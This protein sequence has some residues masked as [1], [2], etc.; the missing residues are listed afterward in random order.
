M[1]DKSKKPIIIWLLSGCILIYL[2]LLIGGITRLTHSGLSIVNWSLFGDFPP[3]NDQQWNERFGQYKQY[4][5]YQQVNF[6][7][8]LDEFKSIF[9]W[10]YIHRFLGR[11]IGVLFI[12]PF[13]YFLVRRRIDSKLLFRLLLLIIL[14]GLQGLLG[15][16]MVQSGLNKLPR[17]SHYRLAAHLIS[18]LTVMGYTFWTAL[19]LIY[20]PKLTGS[21]GILKTGLFKMKTLSILLFVSIVIQIVYGAFVAGLKAGLLCPDWPKMC[22]EWIPES[23]YALRPLWKNTLESGAGVQFIHR[24]MACVVVLLTGIIYFRSKSEPVQGA[25]QMKIVNALGILILCQFTLGI[26]TLLFAVPVVLG[27]LHQTG[28]FLVFT[29]SLFLIFSFRIQK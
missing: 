6:N 15:W 2:M 8:K 1:P 19:E 12:V 20:K 25:L 13:F 27:V 18:A 22:G 3:L 14:G 21:P 24:C 28:A 10:E 17:V 26:L 7:F 29:C 16:Y 9:W 4:P 23:A 5:E 11:S